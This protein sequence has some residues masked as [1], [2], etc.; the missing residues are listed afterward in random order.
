VLSV[1]P[2][3]GPDA[4]AWIRLVMPDGTCLEAGHD[5]FFIDDH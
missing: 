1:P 3:L 2:S 4:A 5:A